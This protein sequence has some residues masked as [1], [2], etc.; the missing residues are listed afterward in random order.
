MS[1]SR[2]TI[3]PQNREFNEPRERCKASCPYTIRKQSGRARL[4]TT[5]KDC[6]NNQWTIKSPAP[7]CCRSHCEQ[8][9]RYSRLKLLFLIRF[10]FSNAEVSELSQGSHAATRFR[11]IDLGVNYGLVF[12]DGPGRESNLLRLRF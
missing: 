10:G 4:S 1:E 8:G 12:P 6:R 7:H 2:N 9:H 3:S 11:R 5:T